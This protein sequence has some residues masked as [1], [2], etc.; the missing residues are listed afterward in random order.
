MSSAVVSTSAALGRPFVFEDE[1]EVEVRLPSNASRASLDRT[2]PST[3][4]RAGLGGSPHTNLQGVQESPLARVQSAISNQKSKI[5][6]ASVTPASR[7]EI[8]PAPA[9]VS[10]GISALDALTGS[11][12]RG[13]LAKILGP[14]KSV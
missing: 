5:P 1:T 14:A 8:R 9:M 2:A 6:P 11:L 13:S 3:L 10:T 7:L 4:L 12:P